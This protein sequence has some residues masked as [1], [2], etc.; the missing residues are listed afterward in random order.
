MGIVAVPVVARRPPTRFCHYDHLFVEHGPLPPHERTWRHPSELAAEERQLLLSETPAASSKAFALTTGTLGLIAIAILLL[1]VT[2]S[3]GG[4]TVAVS[5]TSPPAIALGGASGA[6][7]II[8]ARATTSPVTTARPVAPTETPMTLATP[9]G[10]GRYA[11]ALRDA[12]DMTAGT[13]LD[14]VL[15]SGRHTWGRVID[16]NVIGTD[17]VLL[18]LYDAEPGHLVARHRPGARDMVTVLSSPPIEVA[19]ADIASLQV[20]SGTAIIDA[21]GEL[22]GLCEGD[23]DG[24]KVVDIDVT[25]D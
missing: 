16:T 11:V 17:A 6:L 1:T 20:Q 21:A 25:T 8:G 22:V 12:V 19:F 14:V 23:S 9:I 7:T 13:T 15:P 5:A 18:H 10:E 4:Q 2:P 24:I 3:P